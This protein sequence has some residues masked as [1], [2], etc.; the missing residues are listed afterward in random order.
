LEEGVAVFE[1]HDFSRAAGPDPLH[2]HTFDF[3]RL[4]FNP[5]K[6]ELAPP[7][8]Q[9]FQKRWWDPYWRTAPA[10][11]GDRDQAVVLLLKAELERVAAPARHLTEWEAGQGAGLVIAAAGWSAPAVIIDAA[12]RLA[13]LRPPLPPP[14]DTVA[15]ITHFTFD[16]QH[17]FALARDDAPLGVLYAA[18]RAS[19]RAV[20]A[21]P[22]DAAA[23]VLLGQ[24]YLRLLTSTRER[25]WALR[26]PQLAQL[27][28][29][30]ASAAFYRAICLNPDLAQAHLELGRLYQRIN[31]LD[32]AL[33][34]FQA[35][36]ATAK[37]ESGG[38]RAEAMSSEEFEDLARLVDRQRAKF[39]PESARTRVV[40]RAQRALQRGLAGEARA[41]LLESDVS[42]FGSEGAELELDLL[43][44]TG[45]AED[46]RNWIA[47]EL[48]GALGTTS[49]HW[50]RV[51]ALAA[52][53]DYAAAQA[54]LAELS[55]GPGPDPARTAAVFGVLVGRALLD[56]Q[57]GGFGP[58]AFSWVH[59]RVTFW[60]AFLQA[61]SGLGERAD[62]AVL[63]GLLA[64]EAGEVE[65]ARAA[66]L[67]AMAC[68]TDAPE[69]PGLEFNSRPVVHEALRLLQ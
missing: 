57:P 27:R 6:T 11:T 49:Y 40:D 3:H 24:C 25:V 18:I 35:Y 7:S 33:A 60:S 20:A 46:V 52:L 32:L 63:R 29:A 54:E 64:L 65:Q 34:E 21:D 22:A 67:A 9:K 48:K 59:A 31:C 15:P 38:E 45:R 42:A 17:A 66:F 2:G 69:A 16:R 53:G 19:R 37:R 43:L 68:S 39:A 62:A 14:G 5:A 10:S 44:R 61:V 12:I 26:L 58:M 23:Y 41:I 50:L 1:R 55:G 36:R 8:V 28:Q 47:E 56:E 30:Q 4:A 13:V 51:Q